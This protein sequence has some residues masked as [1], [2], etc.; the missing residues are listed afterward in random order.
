MPR[1][2]HIEPREPGED[3]EEA[4]HASEASERI[5]EAFGDGAEQ[6]GRDPGPVKPAQMPERLQIWERHRTPPPYALKEIQGG[7][8]K[9]FTDVNPQWRR[10]ALTELF[11]PVGMGWKTEITQEWTFPPGYADAGRWGD[12]KSESPPHEV[13]CFVKMRLY[14]RL[15]DGQ[16]SEPIEGQGG[17]KLVTV[18]GE[19]QN[20][21]TKLSDEGWKMATTDAFSVCCAQLGIA[22]DV[23]MG[24]MDT[25][26]QRDQGDGSSKPAQHSFPA[27]EVKR[28]LSQPAR[29]VEIEE[30]R[31]PPAPKPEPD[32]PLCDC[33]AP[34]KSFKAG[35]KSKNPGRWFYMCAKQRNDATRC[36]FFEWVS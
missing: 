15:P 18:H 22:A 26:Y 25:K 8:L 3:A 24:R 36:N 29:K 17:S 28:S 7:P 19:G 35:E 27:G 31:D 4:A 1:S 14:Y 20:R 13:A 33:N 2:Q 10:L 5:R 16:W 6:L 30:L 12:G 32:V 23:Y 34:A 11:G 21:Y 9:G